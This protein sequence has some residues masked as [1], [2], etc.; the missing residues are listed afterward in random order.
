MWLITPIGFFSIVRKPHDD[1]QGTLT[2][3][4]RVATDLEALRIHYLPELGSVSASNFSDYKFRASAPRKAVM[5][6]MAMM[7]ESICYDNFKNEVV[8]QQG[9]DRAHLYHDVWSDL[10]KLQCDPVYQG[11]AHQGVPA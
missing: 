5:R 3:R 6:A 10:Y 1:K 8:R 11:S 7:V 4:A 9:A 2:I